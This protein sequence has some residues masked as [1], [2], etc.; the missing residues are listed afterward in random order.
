MEVIQLDKFSILK[1][2]IETDNKGQDKSKE[3]SKEESKENSKEELQ[4]RTENNG[5]ILIREPGSARLQPNMYGILRNYDYKTYNDPLTP[6]YKRDDY[7]IPAHVI[8]P[9]NFGIYTRGGPTAFKKM[10]YLNNKN[11]QPGDPYKFLTLMGRQK[12]YN[13]TQYEYYIVSTNRDENIKFDLNK[14]RELYSGDIVK[15]PELNDTEYDVN[16]DKNLDYDYSP[17]II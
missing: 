8:D 5:P 1:Y 6:P 14:K 11:A 13:S 15:I 12:Y 3:E 2:F 7:M 17:Y 10:G 4:E 16:I 9:Y